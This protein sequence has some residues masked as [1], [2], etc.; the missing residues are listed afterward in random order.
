MLEFQLFGRPR[1]GNRVG[2]GPGK[3]GGGRVCGGPGPGHAMHFING[4]VC[5]EN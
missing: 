5:V 1:T 2:P 4:V 3:G